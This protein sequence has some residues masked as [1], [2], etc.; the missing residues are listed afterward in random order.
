MRK[1]AA[2][3][4]FLTLLSAILLFAQRLTD[5]KDLIEK[6]LT[7]WDC[8]ELRGSAKTQDG[9]ER[10]QGKNRSMVDLS[11]LNIPD[12]DTAGFL[13]AVSAFDAQTK[14]L[15][16]KDLSYAQK[17]Q[18]AAI[19]KNVVSFTGYLVLAYPGPP[20]TTNCGSVEF[21]DWHLEVFEKPMDHPP[22]IGDPTPIICEIT[23]RQ[24]NMFFH[25]GYRLQDLAAFMRRPDNTHENNGHPARK[26][27]FTGYLLW[28]DDHNGEADIGP[29][30][31]G[32]AKN[33]Y[34]HPWRSTA[35]EVHPVLKMEV[36]D[37]PPPGAAPATSVPAP[38]TAAAPT[39]LEQADPPPSVSSPAAT[40]NAP[41]APT[42]VT[43][44]EPVKIKI[45]YGETVIPRG[46]KVEVIAR[47]AHTVTVRYLGQDAVVPLA[48]TDLR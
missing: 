7:K 28:D 48:S 18:L 5:D 41:A 16:R 15:R 6:D 34:H 26:I 23:P 31:T 32:K 45:P 38:P 43:I 12:L 39:T 1:L 21:H 30:I 40:P 27:R 9:V 10:N 22:E 3:F 33:G 14:G 44:L 24:Q 35:F 8:K 19:E 29:R 36:L 37:G 25:A 2:Y 47:D 4:V 42:S 13:K 17:I 20:E 46:A 11:R